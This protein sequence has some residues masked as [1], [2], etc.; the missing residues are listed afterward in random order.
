MH[1]LS[2][3]PSNSNSPYTLYTPN[4]SNMSRNMTNIE[5]YEML[6]FSNS[7]FKNSEA[8]T[9]QHLTTN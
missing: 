1:N 2:I 9:G 3:V 6:K 8:Q 7:V 5:I 4:K